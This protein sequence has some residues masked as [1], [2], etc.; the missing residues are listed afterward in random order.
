MIR[1]ILNWFRD[2]YQTQDPTDE[3]RVGPSDDLTIDEYRDQIATL[4]VRLATANARI[5]ALQSDDGHA[6]EAALSGA[7]QGGGWIGAEDE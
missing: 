7:R 3:E 2:P 6:A 1:R 5:A 4:R